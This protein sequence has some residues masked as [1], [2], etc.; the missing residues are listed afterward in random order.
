[1]FKEE[2]NKKIWQFRGLIPPRWEPFK[3][4]KSYSPLPL[5]GDGTSNKTTGSCRK[6]N[7]SMVKADTCGM[8]IILDG[9]MT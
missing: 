5:L 3:V 4:S 8:I 1:M 2:I 9:P 7:A 6:G